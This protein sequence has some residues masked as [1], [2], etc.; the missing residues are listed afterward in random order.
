MCVYGEP[1]WQHLIKDLPSLFLIEC[2]Q[3]RRCHK[4]GCHSDVQNCRKWTQIQGCQIFIGT[5]YQKGG[6]AY[7]K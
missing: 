7:T 3:Q 5:T 4:E 2:K 1:L 6:K